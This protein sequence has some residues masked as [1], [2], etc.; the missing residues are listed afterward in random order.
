MVLLREKKLCKAKL[1]YM[2]L[3]FGI[4]LVEPSFEFVAKPRSCVHVREIKT[5]CRNSAS[6]PSIP[7]P[8]ISEVTWNTCTK[9]S[10]FHH[11]GIL[12]TLLSCNQKSSARIPARTQTT[13]TE[14]VLAFPHD[15]RST[16]GQH[17]LPSCY[18]T[19][20]LTSTFAHSGLRF[21]K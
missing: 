1:M 5:A 14:I 7:L 16:S 8:L 12:P 13:L 15:P 21:Y 2:N 11:R 4:I 10:V 20:P 6:R 3:R 18:F 17:R 19:N 9:F